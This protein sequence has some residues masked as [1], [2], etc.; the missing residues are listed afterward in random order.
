MA[1]FLVR[2]LK[3]PPGGAGVFTDVAATTHASDIATIAAAGITTGCGGTSYC[4]FSPVTRA[5]MA[6]FLTR[7]FGL[8]RVYPQISVV[9]GIAST[10]SKDGL[11]CR[12]SITVPYRPQ[13][14][15]REGFYDFTGS[16]SLEATS[17]RVELTINGSALALTPL[18]VESVEGTRTRI[19][20]GIFSLVP[21]THTLVA[22]W[23]WNGF[24][25]QTMTVSVTVRA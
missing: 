23:Y 21:G 3:L 14:E 18:P 25:E 22:R 10:C 6:S 19:F 4:P 12:G 15:L 5:Q 7:A 11:I 9:E 17:T 16:P 8:A 20:R 2:A 1:T 24:L 13:Y